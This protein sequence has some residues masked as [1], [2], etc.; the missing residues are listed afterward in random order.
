[1]KI[2]LFTGTSY[3]L[4][5]SNGMKGNFVWLKSIEEEKKL[6]N[7][8]LNTCISMNMCIYKKEN[9]NNIRNNSY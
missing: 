3:S 4:F 2:N 5:I 6:V 9:Q 1:M 8:S 7:I